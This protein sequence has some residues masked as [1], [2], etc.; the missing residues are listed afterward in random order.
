M[1]GRASTLTPWRDSGTASAYF[2][3]KDYLFLERKTMAGSISVLGLGSGLQLQDILDKLREA[4]E[5]PI[6]RL[7]TEKTHYQ[8]QLTAFDQ[9]NQDLLTIKSHALNL[10]LQ[11]T[12]IARNVS[13]SDDTV[14]S[15]SVSDGAATGS[16]RLTVNRLATFSSWQG[17]GLSDTDSVV[18]NT[19][20]DETFSY[21]IGSGDTISLTVPDGTTLE[22]L[23]SLINDDTNNPGVTASVID[24]GDTS[25]PYRLLLKADETGE[26][27]RIYVDSQLSGYTLTE[28]Q[29]ASSSSLN[30]EVEVDG[31]VYQ[32][33]G[34]SGIT[35]IIGGVTL[36]LLD[37]GTASVSVSS[38]IEGLKDSI[39]NLV[40][41]FNSVIS[42]IK[43]QTGYDSD[44]TPGLLND[45][46]TIKSLRYQLLD[47][48][49]VTID[50]GGSVQSMFDLGLEVNRDGT[51]TLDE[52]TLDDALSSNF[53]DVQS[54]F[55]GDDSNSVT[56][57]ADQ[58]NDAL[59]E[60]TRPSTGL[61]ATEHTAADERIQRIDA[62]IES[63]TARLD[64]KYEILAQ[65]FAQLDN[66]MNN[67][68]SM[69]SY[70]T[71]QFDAISGKKE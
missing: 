7:E 64:R 12:F 25:T 16:Y 40:D 6:N 56:G 26:T 5:A 34:N 48:L 61:M 53:S 22:E 63:T 2:N 10:S 27:S 37:T 66:F 67:M 47:M 29:G 11:S 52:T 51:L 24:D 18:N 45:S 32:R 3:P 49:S 69:S 13:S 39:M 54:L 42:S 36:N 58:L 68:Q 15:A 35:D 60:M 9:L 59:R 62:Q 44:G 14:I 31:V 21:H 38:D 28:L 57:L 1:E 4:D 17:T 55:L 20:S 8:D 41:S 70:L 33:T 65:Q 43:D 46:S 30:A 71:S 50:T 23:A 19:G